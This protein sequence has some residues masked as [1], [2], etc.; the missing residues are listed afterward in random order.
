MPRITSSLNKNVAENEWKDMPEYKFRQHKPIRT[1]KI[2]FENEEDIKKFEELFGQKL[3][4]GREN[5]WF[6]GWHESMYSE[7]VYVDS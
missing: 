1:I 2:N 4:L 7:S 5:Y 3:L 6:P